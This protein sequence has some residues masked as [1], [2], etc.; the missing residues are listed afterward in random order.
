MSSRRAP[1][2]VSRSTHG[3]VDSL[4][5]D[6]A[7]LGRIL[8]RHFGQTRRDLHPFT[9]KVGLRWVAAP[10]NVGGEV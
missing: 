4:A 6:H 1:R 10:E 5:N 9:S 7:R 2:R 3:L 8:R